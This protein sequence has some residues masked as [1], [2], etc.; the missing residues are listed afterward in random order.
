[1][2]C[3]MWRSQWLNLYFF[4]VL[5][6]GISKLKPDFFF[7][8]NLVFFPALHGNESAGITTSTRLSIY[9]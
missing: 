9:C 3:I 2:N 8:K 4:I 7:V 5:V 6:S 1:M